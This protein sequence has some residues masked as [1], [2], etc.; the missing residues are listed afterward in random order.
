VKLK[1]PPLSRRAVLRGLG[2]AMALPMLD[3]M[4]PTMAFAQAAPT[5]PACRFLGFYVP[6]GIHMAGWR[7]ARPGADYDMPPILAPLTDLRDQ[8]LVLGNLRNEPA[9]PDG[10]GDHAA[11]TGSF[12]TAAHC[13]KTDGANIKNGISID[14]VIANAVGGEHRF[15]SLALGSESG[16]NAG[17]CDSGYSCAY[18]RNISW[19]SETTPAAKDFNARV[20]FDRLFGRGEGGLT[21]AQMARKA[22]YRRSVLDVVRQDARALQ[23]KL[24]RSDRAKLDEYLTGVRELERQLDLGA[25]AACDPGELPGR[26]E[27]WSGAVRQMSDLMLAAVRCDLTPVITYMLGNGGSGR[28]LPW[29]GI[30]DAH[31]QI[32]HH[33]GNPANLAKLQTIDI[34]EVEQLAY[35]LRGLRDIEEAD[36]RT[37]LD[38]SVVF[39]SSEVE[40]GN[41]HSHYDMPVLVAGGGAGRLRTGRHLRTPEPRS[42]ADLF[43]TLAEVCGAPAERFGDSVGPLDLS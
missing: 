26:S 10:P 42:V 33:Q 43:L 22:R 32:S 36:G 2:A 12:L 4:R 7:P 21:P 18:S 14:Q 25:Q 38:N 3:A 31:H 29:L 30:R 35:L 5:Q 17:G 19:Q 8:L 27:D 13:F 40:D 37:A 39:F 6:N 34:W 16:S 1:T 20:V 23:A 9:R 41:S 15:R 11:G 28:A 24:G